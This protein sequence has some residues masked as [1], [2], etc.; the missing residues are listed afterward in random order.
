MTSQVV[1]ITGSSKGIG[2]E[3]ALHLARDLQRRFKVYAT[4]RNQSTRQDDL[5]AKAGSSLDVTLFIREL[6]VTK[7]ETI[8]KTVKEIVE[9]EGRI[10]ILAKD[11]LKAKAG[12]SLDDTLFIREL[13]VTKQE[14]IDK[15]VKEIADSEGRIDVLVNN[16]GVLTPHW[17]ETGPTKSFYDIMEVN[18][19]G[20]VRMTKAVVPYMKKQRSG[21]ILQFSSVIGLKAVPE[22][23]QYISTKF[24]LEGF[25]ES[26]APPLRKFNVWVSVIQIGHVITE[27]TAQFGPNPTALLKVAAKEIP[28]DTRGIVERMVSTN[29]EDVYGSEVQTTGDIA[30]FMEE[31][32]LSEKPNFRY[33]TSQS[34]QEVARRRLLDPTGNEMMDTWMQQ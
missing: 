29:P 11:D 18:F 7:Q 16:A 1:L 8:D 24:A 34:I 22:L 12:S 25:S 10:D 5:K 6:D 3:L 19:F 32:I 14:T 33:Q 9:R 4:M 17:W 27:M 26:I 23:A 2:L 21:R 15:T 28:E 20:C 31:V 13:D 30:K